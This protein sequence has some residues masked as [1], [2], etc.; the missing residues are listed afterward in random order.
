M[1]FEWSRADRRRLAHDLPHTL[2]GVYNPK[3]LPT[4]TEKSQVGRDSA[5]GGYAA[6][7]RVIKMENSYIKGEHKGPS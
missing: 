5:E 3:R 2:M 1:Y 6:I 4:A 7:Y